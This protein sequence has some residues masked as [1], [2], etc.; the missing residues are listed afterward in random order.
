MNA[1]AVVLRAGGFLALWL[2]LA[3]STRRDLPAAAVAVAAATWVSL[4]SRCHR[5]GRGFPCRT[6]RC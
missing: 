1:P 5:T 3:G 2:V 4:R 6:W